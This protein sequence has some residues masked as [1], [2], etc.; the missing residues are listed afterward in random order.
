MI[1][2]QCQ[3]EL[4]GIGAEPPGSKSEAP[5][6]ADLGVQQPAI[7]G[8]LRLNQEQPLR[9]RE[10]GKQP[11]FNGYQCGLG[12]GQSHSSQAKEIE[13]QP[14]AD[15]N[16]QHGDTIHQRKAGKTDAGGKPEVTRLRREVLGKLSQL[17]QWIGG[18]ARRWIQS[19]D[20][21]VFAKL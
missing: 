18:D 12:P 9:G 8:K 15:G 3:N 4:A 20:E 5:C 11:Q 19:L 16:R 21:G 1:A 17:L 13:F 6:K 2:A 10:P 7:V 14:V